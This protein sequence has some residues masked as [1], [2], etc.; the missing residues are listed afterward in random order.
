MRVTI[1]MILALATS[2]LPAQNDRGG[3][4]RR[5]DIRS[6]VSALT[7]T[8]ESFAFTMNP[9]PAGWPGEEATRRIRGTR[10]ASGERDEDAIRDVVKLALRV[11]GD[12]EARKLRVY[13]TDGFLYATGDPTFHGQVA[14]FL[15][16]LRRVLSDTVEVELSVLP[17]EALAETSGAVLDAAKADRLASVARPLATLRTEIRPGS[18]RLLEAVARRAYV[19]DYDTEVAQDEKHSD[20]LIDVICEGLRASVR[21][22]E[23]PNGGFAVSIEG[24]QAELDGPMRAQLLNF[25]NV[26]ATLQLPRT[27]WTSTSASARI[28]N[29]GALIVGNDAV[30]R[31]VWMLRV[32]APA[33][34]P[35]D[36]PMLRMVPIGAA[37]RARLQA[38]P[39][40]FRS[41]EPTGGGPG[42]G[43]TAHS[44]E[45]PQRLD[46]D[47]L[48]E[49][50][51]AAGP[52]GLPE[53]E[54][55]TLSV[56][57]RIALRGDSKFVARAADAL[58]NAIIDVLHTYSIEV[59]AGTVAAEGFTLPAHDELDTL[60]PGLSRRAAT[61]AIAG[62]RVV[63]I[64]GQS[65]SYLK[66]R[67]AEIAQQESTD[68]PV[69][70]SF[71]TGLAMSCRAWPADEGR[72]SIE[73]G[74]EY[75]ELL[76]M[77]PVATGSS[78]VPEVELPRIAAVVDS[79]R[80]ETA[81][82][83]WRL[84][85]AGPLHGTDRQ[86]VVMIRVSRL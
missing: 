36:D 26:G 23:A 48:M 72:C 10:E 79:M 55:R 14:R 80:A 60:A 67:D 16:E 40:A 54:R 39:P 28:E 74:L 85:H 33:R 24:Q 19:K 2:I 7:E 61:A 53:A 25:K 57:R 82:G 46:Y 15:A 49:L 42:S 3:E 4:L 32:S 62:D 73:V 68:D 44:E 45:G 29:R 47:R 9:A 77:T 86:L 84:V 83:S 65:Q 58:T 34:N 1:P 71:F 35:N 37:T 50:V 69:V 38:A 12:E 8:S 18:Q 41:P 78:E 17:S 56:S 21:V 22:D 63:I 20:P 52:E 5:Y 30:P 51:R 27:W 64:A 66:D 70:D 11:D 31:S 81:L 76:E 59:R 75:Q 43:T 13:T 6:L